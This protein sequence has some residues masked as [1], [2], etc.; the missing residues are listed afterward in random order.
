MKSLAIIVGKAVYPRSLDLSRVVIISGRT[1]ELETMSS[2]FEW[3]V[4]EKQSIR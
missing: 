3:S 1:V 4:Q 2:F